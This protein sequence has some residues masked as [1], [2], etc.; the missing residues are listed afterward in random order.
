MIWVT[1]AH[2]HQNVS[3][4]VWIFH[5]DLDLHLKR[6]QFLEKFQVYMNICNM[7]AYF[8]NCKFHKI[9]IQIA[10]F[11]RKFSS[12]IAVFHKY[13]LGFKIW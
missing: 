12:Q 11:Q 8:L 13:T 10:Y 9:E 3:V 4:E 5:L 6:I 2:D 1:Q 7:K